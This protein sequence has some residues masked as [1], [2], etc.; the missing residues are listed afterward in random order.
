MCLWLHSPHF[1]AW[2]HGHIHQNSRNPRAF[3][4]IGNVYLALLQDGVMILELD[5]DWKDPGSNP[6]QQW[7]ILSDSHYLTVLDL[8]MFVW[9]HTATINGNSATMEIGLLYD[10]RTII[11]IINIICIRYSFTKEVHKVLDVAKNTK[12]S[13]LVPDDSQFF[14]KRHKRVTRK[15][16]LEKILCWSN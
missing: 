10:I 6:T 9:Y 14:F 13:I 12:R 15:W 5:E 11:I 4:S 1:C 2:G 16:L 3:A 7:S 8:Y